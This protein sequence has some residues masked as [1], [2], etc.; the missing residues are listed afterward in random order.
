MKILKIDS[1]GN[2][3]YC[4]DGETDIPITNISKNDIYSL[5]EIIYNEPD[6]NNLIDDASKCHIP[7]EIER[8]IYQN[9]YE[10]I[11][12]FIQNKNALK[13]EIEN[14]LKD[15]VSKYKNQ[16]NESEDNKN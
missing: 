3:F 1:K 16:L 2:C 15:V 4:I 5:L 8:I 14:E 9:I 6:C 11:Q 12:T 10:K 7:N 13:N